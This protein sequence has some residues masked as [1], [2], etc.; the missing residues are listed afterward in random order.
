MHTTARNGK[1]SSASEVDAGTS[2]DAPIASIL[3]IAYN[4]QA[5][6]VEAIAGALAQTYSP[7]EIVVSDDASSDDTWAHMQHAVAGYAGPH[8]VV[9]NRNEHNLGIGAHLSR[10]VE[11]SRG[12]LLFV[13]AGVYA[14]KVLIFSK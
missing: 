2:A 9:L 10:V 14:A 6:I 3:L 1:D 13:A 7:L 11:L 4:Q 5:T 12:V 8:R